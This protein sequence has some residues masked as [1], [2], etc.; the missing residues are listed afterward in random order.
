M[1]ARSWLAFAALG[2]IWGIPYLLIKL[3]I[4]ELEPLFIAWARIAL[5]ALVLLP[6]ALRRGALTAAL[7]YWKPIVAF[8]VIEFVIPFSAITVG[9]Q[10]VSSSVTGMLIAMAPLSVALISRFFG[11]HERLGPVRLLGLICGFVGVATLLGF[12][13]VQGVLGWTGVGCMI[14]AT[15][16]YAIGALIVQRNLSHLDPVGPIAASLSV[17]ALILLPAA[18]A[19]FPRHLPSATAIASV[20]TLGIACSAI[21]MLLMF[22]LIREAGAARASVITYVN[23]AVAALLGVLVLN[24]TLGFSGLVAFALILLGSWLATRG[25]RA[26]AG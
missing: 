1:H 12:G 4:T 17:A 26:R 19:G 20:A 22:F 21:A 10:W 6:V 15:L 16:G 5:A 9:E 3:A 18:I 23:P 14:L 24:E 11:L 25:Q 13:S 7:P 8:A 2:L